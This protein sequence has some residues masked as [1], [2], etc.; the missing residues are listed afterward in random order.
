M[1]VTLCTVGGD[2]DFDDQFRVEGYYEDGED[3]SVCF[4]PLYLTYVLVSYSR[5]HAGVHS[6]IHGLGLSDTLEPRFSSQ[7]MVGQPKARKAAGL[8]LKMLQG[9]GT[10]AHETISPITILL[11]LFPLRLSPFPHLHLGTAK[12]LSGRAILFAGPPSTGKTAIALG[13][14]QTLGPDVPFTSISASEVFSLSLSK[15]E[16]LTQVSWLCS[17]V[18]HSSRSDAD[19][20]VILFFSLCAALLFLSVL[21][22]VHCIVL[23]LP[24]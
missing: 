5:P 8:V 1:R 19:H 17:I 11:I 16:G 13:M 14:A 24:A 20:R 3:R 10:Y 12:S 23:R 15:T 22:I 21:F 7:G 2:A 18:L 9:N 6:H 4:L